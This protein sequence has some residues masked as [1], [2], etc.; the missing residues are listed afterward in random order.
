M[1]AAP[2]RSTPDPL[3]L[4][5]LVER[6]VSQRLDDALR[7]HDGDIDQWRILSLLAERGGCPMNAVAD[8]ALLLAPKLSKLVDRMVS[9]NLVLRRTDEHDRR[10]V[11]IAVTPRGRQALAAWDAASA[12][13]RQEFRDLLGPDA[14]LLDDLLGRLAHGLTRSPASVPTS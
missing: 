3:R 14:A 4:L 7:A 8:H 6:A 12:A 11:L 5:S 1:A 13:V 9:A 10:R 2:E